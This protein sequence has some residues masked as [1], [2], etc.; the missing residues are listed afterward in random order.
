MDMLKMGARLSAKWFYEQLWAYDPVSRPED[1]P[2]IT[3]FIP[4]EE[5][6]FDPEYHEKSGAWQPVTISCRGLSHTFHVDLY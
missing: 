1:R 6:A 4:D 5:F 2:V 3:D